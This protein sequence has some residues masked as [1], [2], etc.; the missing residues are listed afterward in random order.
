MKDFL[1]GFAQLLYSFFDLFLNILLLPL[2]LGWWVL[3]GVNAKPDHQN[4]QDQ[5]AEAKYTN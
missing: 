4:D 3:L 2:V 1:D 5:T